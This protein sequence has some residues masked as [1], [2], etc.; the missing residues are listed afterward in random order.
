[1]AALEGTLRDLQARDPSHKR[2]VERA[3]K[4]LSRDL[5]QAADENAQLRRD[6]ESL[7]QVRA[8][9]E[10]AAFGK[11]LSPEWFRSA[12]GVEIPIPTDA[13]APELPA[14]PPVSTPPEKNPRSRRAEDG[15]TRL[16]A[17]RAALARQ[18]HALIQT[19]VQTVVQTLIRDHTKRSA[20][21]QREEEFLRL[22]LDAA[23]R[24]RLHVEA[25]VDRQVAEER[26]E[27][28]ALRREVTRLRA[29]KAA[30]W[31]R[32]EEGADQQNLVGD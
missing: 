30:Q 16:A 25:E 24:E 26:Q 32:T 10:H 8:E 11:G 17:C 13:A 15:E 2:A 9:A 27:A 12:L 23:V 21:W 22:R 1:V 3:T 28:E 31:R 5:A 4:D 19:V 6:L 18:H 29:E 14:G 7:R 20:A